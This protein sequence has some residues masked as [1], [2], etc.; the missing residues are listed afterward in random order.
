MNSN[1]IDK[2]VLWNKKRG[3]DKRGFDLQNEVSYLYSE[4]LEL[5]GNKCPNHDQVAFEYIKDLV[6]QRT[7]IL[8]EDEIADG[9]GD[10]IVYCIG[11]L[12]KLGYEPT[13]VLEIINDAN[14]AKSNNVNELG[15]ITKSVHFQKPNLSLAKIIKN[16]QSD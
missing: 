5:T 13:K 16:K 11:A 12:F 4:I 10:I 1:V 8:T 14:E 3:L 15:K 7:Q 9:F 2:I 6:S